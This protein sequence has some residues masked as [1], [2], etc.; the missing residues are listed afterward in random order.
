[1][2]YREAG[3]WIGTPLALLCVWLLFF[4]VPM[5][6]QIEARKSELAGVEARIATVEAQRSQA[7]EVMS[8]TF[9]TIRHYP[10]DQI[11][12][13]QVFPEFMKKIASSVRKGGVTVDRLKG[14]LDDGSV[15]TGSALAYP[16]TEIALTGQFMDIGRVLEQIQTFKA[17]R[18][19]VRA[20]LVAKENVYPDIKGSVEIEFR[21]WRD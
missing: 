7:Q 13:L 4:C 9:E 17:Y 15:E 20:Q 2:R 16:V 11:P 6:S 10:L 14:R 8:D 12:H 1:M 21:A 5:A 3:L 18:R 19:I